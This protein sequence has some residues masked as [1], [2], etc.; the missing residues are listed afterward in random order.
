[1][2]QNEAR[3][4]EDLPVMSGLDDVLTPLNMIPNTEND[5]E[6]T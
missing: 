2:T 5:L 1:M 4:L 3:E 6:T